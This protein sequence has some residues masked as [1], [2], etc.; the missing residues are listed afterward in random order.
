MRW[1]RW[2]IVTACLVIT[3]TI[4]GGC[5]GIEK[6]ER[7]VRQIT[8]AETTSE[9]SGILENMDQ[10][11]EAV[12]YM[13]MNHSE[14]EKF[15][16]NTTDMDQ[17]EAA[18]VKGVDQAS[19]VPGYYS[20]V[21]GYGYVSS[22]YELTVT[23]EYYITKEDLVRSKEKADEVLDAIVT[24]EMSDY[25]KVL[26]IHDYIVNNTSYAQVFNEE[27]LK[28]H[29][30]FGVLI[31]G[32]AV[33]QGYTDAFHYMANKAGV[34]TINVEGKADGQSHAWN[35]VD[36]DGEWYHIDTTWD[37]PVMETGEEILNYDFF[38]V[39]NDEILKVHEYTVSDYPIADSSLHNYYVMTDRLV[40]S[41]KE[42]VDRLNR[43]FD[44]EESEMEVKADFDLDE[45]YMEK[46]LESFTQGEYKT[47]SYSI[48]ED[49]DRLWI[50][51]VHYWD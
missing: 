23:V 49:S 37:D 12:K 25:E 39:T 36:I 24:E 50:M 44:R 29:T 1:N 34:R 38:N 18:I 19:L 7:S 10:L 13:V 15:L 35:M 48:N 11:E 30:M 26:V 8:A 40:K 22:G 21:N 41:E 4:S 2:I 27:N 45:S 47:L 33:C 14:K 43:L 9:T 51:D 32:Q 3:L 5:S 6:V 28:A 42:L 16:M 31:D 17:V 46:L 20:L